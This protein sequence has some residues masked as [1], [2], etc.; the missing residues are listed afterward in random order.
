MENKEPRRYFQY[1][2]GG[3]R[4]EV[5]IYDHIEEEDDMVF[6]CFKDKSRCNDELILP[7]NERNPGS[8]LMAEVENPNNVWTFKEE[9][10][11]RQ[12][13]KRA[14]DA[15]GK[16]QIVQPFIEG[17]KVVTPVPPKRTKSNF[18]QI[19]NHI[20][21]PTSTS[22][23]PA[24]VQQQASI[25]AQR[26]KMSDPVWVMMD[27]A[28][29]FDTEVEMTLNIALPAKSL[30][31]VAKESFEEGGQ[32]VIEYIIDNLDDTKLK[33]ALKQALQI[34]YN[35]VEVY[36]DERKMEKLEVEGKAL[37]KIAEVQ[38]TELFEPGE[39]GAASEPIAAK[40][41]EIQKIKE[42]NE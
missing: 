2:A 11:G 24:N 42:E 31:N 21:I 13:E 3:R 33:K 30:Y 22:A 36:S 28:K 37:E 35:D 41:E 6:V 29:K 10:K 1:I 7:I 12:E 4:G 9:W 32:K 25:D 14:K 34:A 38:P 19:T 17:R 27:K 15:D 8:A 23:Q 16:L 20:E 39:G 18:G 40:P 26:D 5:V